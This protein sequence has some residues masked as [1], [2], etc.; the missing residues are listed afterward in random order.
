MGNAIP[1]IFPRQC[2]VFSVDSSRNSL[3]AMF[4][5]FYHTHYPQLILKSQLSRLMTCDLIR[6]IMTSRL[7]STCRSVYIHFHTMRLMSRDL[8]RGQSRFMACYASNKFLFFTENNGRNCMKCIETHVNAVACVPMHFRHQTNIQFSVVGQCTGRPP[9]IICLIRVS[10]LNR[11]HLIDK[12]AA[13]FF[14]FFKSCI[15]T[16]SH[17]TKIN[18]FLLKNRKFWHHIFL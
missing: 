16:E 7:T 2:C 15:L 9:K 17:V 10:S 4:I 14:T 1:P 13:W 11:R 18:F 12:N 6:D 3:F 8:F 5:Y